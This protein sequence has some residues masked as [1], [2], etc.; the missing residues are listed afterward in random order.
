MKN[1]YL[2]IAAIAS[3]ALVSC[4]NEEFVGELDPGSGSVNQ[5]QITFGTFTPRI[6]R[7]EGEAA[8][9]QLGNS[10]NVYATKTVS[11]TTSNVFAK[12]TYAETTASE[13][14]SANPY[15]VTW[16]TGTAG[17]TTSNTSNWEYVTGDQTIK[18]WDYAASQYDFVAYKATVGNPTITKYRT[19]GFTVAATAAELAGLYVA[20]KL[21]ITNKNTTPST[22]ADGSTV[23]QIGDIV[24]FTF[25]SSATK[26]RLGIYE[27]IPGYVVQNV[28][29]RG[30]NAEFTDATGAA[31]LC[32]SFNGSSSAASG[33]FDVTYASS[34]PRIAIFTR[35]SSATDFSSNF[36]DFGSFV[37][38]AIGE[39]STAPTWA[40]GSSDYQGVFPNTDNVGNM[41]LYVDYELYNATSGE[42]INVK[43][44]KAVVPA[45]YM[46]WNPNYAYTYLFKISDNTNGYTGTENVNPAGLYPITFDAV[47]IA[48][49]D[50]QE[51]GTITT[52]TT[53]AITTYQVGSVVDDV[54]TSKH[55]IT[56]ANANGPIYITVN[57]DGTLADLR[58]DNI[59]LY[60]VD[61]GTTEAD[62]MLGVTSIHKTAV[63]DGTLQILTAEEKLQGITFAP[64]VTAK[65][66]PTAS[67]TYAVEYQ[68]GAY[69][70]VASP[71]VSEIGSYYERSG[72][73]APYTYTQTT[74]TALDGGKTYYTYK[75]ATPAAYQYKI[76]EVGPNP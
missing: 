30:L 42:T 21:E 22:P 19:T 71:D 45:M 72:S 17:T 12:N 8:A 31:K 40:T 46:T 70:A 56:Y 24:K 33:T 13:T 49:T 9:Q 69:T 28:K 5:G 26:V 37:T 52:V 32:G 16:A 14:S 48:A 25:R 23:N 53:P 39:T 3:V 11:G 66:T 7:A 64:G 41:T 15:V 6:T 43:G 55:G 51:V 61:A 18:Y 50:G 67:I 63:N 36:F 59:K 74:D 34:E 62:L 58:T 54:N 60:T 75:L 76:I 44:A 4:S 73:A 1:S 35:N 27:T 20:D 57:T 2:I 65:F 38:T 68:F 47:T 29:F 10:F